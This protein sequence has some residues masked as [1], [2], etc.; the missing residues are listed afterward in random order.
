MVRSVRVK[1][2]NLKGRYDCMISLLHSVHRKKILK[3][4]DRIL[5]LVHCWFLGAKIRCL[6][7]TNGWTSGWMNEIWGHYE[8]GFLP[9]CILKSQKGGSRIFE[10]PP[11]G[12]SVGL[13]RMGLQDPFQIC[14]GLVSLDSM[15]GF[16][17][18]QS[19]H[20]RLHVRCWE[21]TV[22]PSRWILRTRWGEIL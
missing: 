10:H 17:E 1:Y 7:N 14:I 3:W 21:R 6:V 5:R 2:W 13:R 8:N 19:F 11:A 22:G 20:V 15:S 12:L 16:S 9:Y 4:L 18:W